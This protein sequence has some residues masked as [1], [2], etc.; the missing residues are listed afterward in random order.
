ML[1]IV[2][3]DHGSRQPEAN[4][5]LDA[6]AAALAAARPDARVE[7]AHMELA[8]PNLDDAVDACVAAGA[9]EI[10]VHPF[11]VAPGRH[12]REDVPR[13]VAAAAARHPEV[14]IRLTAPLGLHPSVVDAVNAR[15]DEL[16]E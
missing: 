3:I 5:Q 12:V 4:A 8:A 9:T 14:P 13:L 7:V 2:V 15:L 1:G 16:D 10:R 11:F 6:L